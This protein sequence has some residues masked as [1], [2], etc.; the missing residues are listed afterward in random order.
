MRPVQDSREPLSSLLPKPSPRLLYRPPVRIPSEFSLLSE[1]PQRPTKTPMIPNTRE[2]FK[3]PKYPLIPRIPLRESRCERSWP[4]LL[5]ETR[6]AP[7]CDGLANLP[8]RALWPQC[9]VQRPSLARLSQ[10]A[11]LLPSQSMRLITGWASASTRTSSPNVVR[12][13]DRATRLSSLRPASRRILFL[14]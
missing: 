6:S 9:M 4:D 10:P 8:V 1:D 13:A 12:V 14:L 11:S 5:P 3:S 7:A 2:L